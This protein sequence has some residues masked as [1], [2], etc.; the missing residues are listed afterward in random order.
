MCPKSREPGPGAQHSFRGSGKQA[1]RGSCRQ[2]NFCRGEGREWNFV[3]EGAESDSMN[4]A[5][6]LGNAGLPV[7]GGS[8]GSW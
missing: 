8:W 7:E 5:G 3:G 4:P 2:T 1:V 6:N